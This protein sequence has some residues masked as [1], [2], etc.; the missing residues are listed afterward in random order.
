M[1]HSKKLHVVG[2]CLLLIVIAIVFYFIGYKVAYDRIEN[3]TTSQNYETQTFYATIVEAEETYFLVKG[4][5]VNDINYRGEFTFPIMGETS[6]IWRGTEITPSDLD[7]GDT[8]SITFSGDILETDPG[9]ISDVIKVQ[10][11]DDEV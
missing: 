2:I 9:Q 8:I 4:I 11:L 7:A 6:Y 1:K 5:E 10:L 3:A